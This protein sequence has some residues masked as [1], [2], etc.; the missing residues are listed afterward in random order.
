MFISQVCYFVLASIG[1][2][3][4]AYSPVIVLGLYVS[5]HE[6]RKTAH[7]EIVYRDVRR[8]TYLELR[9]RIGRLASAL[10]KIGVR[11]GDSVGVLDWDSNRFLEAFF[12]IAMWLAVCFVACPAL[13][14]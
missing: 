10:Q 8:L 12:A 9:D 5:L 1:A 3:A 6:D 13:L 11:P 4:L 14:A 7:Q 2:E